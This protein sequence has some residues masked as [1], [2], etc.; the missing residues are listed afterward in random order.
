MLHAQGLQATNSTICVYAGTARSVSSGLLRH[1]SPVGHRAHCAKGQRQSQRVQ[2]QG[3]FGRVFKRPERHAPELVKLD[4]DDE[5][6]LGQTSPE[7]F[8]PLVSQSCLLLGPITATSLCNASVKVAVLQ[9]V[10]MVG[11]H[12][13][14]I[15]AFRSVMLDMEA[16][17]VKVDISQMWSLRKLHNASNRHSVFADHHL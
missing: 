14:E 3:F 10:L 9:A 1:S 12:E 6:G 5:G 4:A 13:H 8:G 2:A 11:F 15:Q 7:L 16:D 17:M